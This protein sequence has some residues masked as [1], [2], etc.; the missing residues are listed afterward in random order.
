MRIR[1]KTGTYHVNSL[2]RT[3]SG[4]NVDGQ[5]SRSNSFGVADSPRTTAATGY[6][7][8]IRHR[9]AV[10]NRIPDSGDSENVTRRLGRFGV[11]AQSKGTSHLE[12]SRETRIAGLAQRLVQ[13]F[14]TQAGVSCDL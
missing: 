8:E 5:H 2:R 12:H 13:A 14:A 7:P 3:G 6:M 9:S 1:G 11:Q 4:P 10:A